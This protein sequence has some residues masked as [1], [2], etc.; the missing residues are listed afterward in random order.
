VQRLV[1]FLEGGRFQN[2]IVRGIV[3]RARDGN[4]LP[5]DWSERKPESSL[6]PELAKALGIG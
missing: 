3:M 2:D 5:G 4:P 6:W 1:R